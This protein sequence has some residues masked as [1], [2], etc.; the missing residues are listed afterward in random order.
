MRECQAR[1]SR[2]LPLE[3]SSRILWAPPVSAVW[4][5]RDGDFPLDERG[6]DFVCC[7]RE[8]IEVQKVS[9]FFSTRETAFSSISEPTLSRG[10]RKKSEGLRFSENGGCSICNSPTLLFSEVNFLWHGREKFPLRVALR[11]TSYG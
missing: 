4:I 10:N 5:S 3:E 11:V 7:I 6:Q 2:L 8:S 9:D 1:G